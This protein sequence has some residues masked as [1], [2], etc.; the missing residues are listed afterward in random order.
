MARRRLRPA[1]K[2]HSKTAGRRA[3]KSKW[4]H[5]LQKMSARNISILK[6]RTE[7][8]PIPTGMRNHA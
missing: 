3:T 5:E 4:W 2:N 7:H 8:R 6:R 1:L